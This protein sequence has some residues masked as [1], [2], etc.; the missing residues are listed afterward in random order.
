[1]A[2]AFAQRDEVVVVCCELCHCDLL[3]EFKAVRII[4][5]MTSRSRLRLPRRGA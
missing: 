3:N 1:M 5:I 2:N 4:E